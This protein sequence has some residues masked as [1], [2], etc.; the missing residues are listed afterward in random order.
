VE[1]IARIGR[2]IAG[3]KDIARRRMPLRP[4][5]GKKVFDRLGTV[6]PEREL[7]VEILDVDESNLQPLPF[8]IGLRPR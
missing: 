3:E 6:R 7:V 1:V 5:A 4:R 2:R 8:V